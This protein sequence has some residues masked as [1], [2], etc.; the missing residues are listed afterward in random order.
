MR[1]SAIDASAIGGGPISRA[2]DCAAAEATPRGSQADKLRLFD[3]FTACCASCT[4]CSRGRCVSRDPRIDA[5]VAALEYADVLI[6]GVPSRLHA[7]DPR[8]VALLR[9]LVSGFACIES[10]REPVGG[11]RLSQRAKVAAMISSAPPLL[12]MLAQMGLIP[13]A[14]SAALGLLERSRVAIVATAWVAGSFSGPASRDRTRRAARRV[15]RALAMATRPAA[16]PRVPVLPETASEPVFAT[17]E[18]RSA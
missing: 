8:A 13:D 7:R 3:L 14:A 9:R 10:S 11:G 6:L 17:A 18:V 16:I 12:G 5:A 15:G 2:V 4:A 1:V